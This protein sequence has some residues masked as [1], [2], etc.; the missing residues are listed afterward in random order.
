MTLAGEID[1]TTYVLAIILSLQHYDGVPEGLNRVLSF[2]ALQRR[3]R[4]F[5]LNMKQLREGSCTTKCEY[6]SSSF[7]KWRGKMYARAGHC[8]STEGKQ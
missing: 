4:R 8:G 2:E 3:S 6:V 5:E 1:K 7:P